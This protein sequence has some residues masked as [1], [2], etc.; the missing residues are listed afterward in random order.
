[1]IVPLFA[2]AN[3]G[4]AISRDSLDRA[5]T[6]AITWGIIAGLVIGKPVGIIVASRLSIRAGAADEP[7]GATRT[8]MLGVAAAGGIGFT[9]ALFITDL[10]FVEERTRTDAKLGV[11]VASLLAAGFAAVALRRTRPSD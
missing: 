7:D 9:V 3:A 2:F 1:M 6:S 10:A 8:G 5:A 4:I 11:L